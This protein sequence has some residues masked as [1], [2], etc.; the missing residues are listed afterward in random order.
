VLEAFIGVK[1]ESK[2][3]EFEK[4]LKTGSGR[5]ILKKRIL[6]DEAKAKSVKTDEALA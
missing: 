5:A 4:Y 3:R 6:T 1:T 2:A